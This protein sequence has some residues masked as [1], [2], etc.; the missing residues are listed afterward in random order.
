MYIHI[1]YPYRYP[2]PIPTPCPI[3]GPCLPAAPSASLLQASLVRARGAPALRR[4]V[5][6][7]GHGEP[8]Q[9]VEQEIQAEGWGNHGK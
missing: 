5:G 2:I 6:R 1:H 3:P 9:A 7:A 8:G 4:A